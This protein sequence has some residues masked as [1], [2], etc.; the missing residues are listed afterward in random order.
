M[1]KVWAKCGKRNVGWRT[2]EGKMLRVVRVFFRWLRDQMRYAEGILMNPGRGE[3]D[4]DG[5]VGG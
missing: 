1:E 3:G 4:G 2:C 5:D